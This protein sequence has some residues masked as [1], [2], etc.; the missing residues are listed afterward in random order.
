M[1]K[2][3]RFEQVE[4]SG[5]TRPEDVSTPA[6]VESNTGQPAKKPPRRARAALSFVR[7]VA[8]AASEGVCF[9]ANPLPAALAAAWKVASQQAWKLAAFLAS[10]KSV[11]VAEFKD[12]LS[13]MLIVVAQG[14][15]VI[16]RR[17]NVPLVRVQTIRNP[18]PGKVPHGVAGCTKGTVQIHGNPT[19]PCI[20]EDDREMLK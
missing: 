11:N 10:S 12:R 16:V 9:Y 1:L 18:A 20:P 17:R 7:E 5:Q 3:R 6:V 13:E 8:Y 4:K 14:G 2:R 19:E 15:E